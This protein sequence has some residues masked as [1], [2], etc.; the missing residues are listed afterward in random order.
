MVKVLQFKADRVFDVLR[1][2]MNPETSGLPYTKFEKPLNPQQQELYLSK[3]IQCFMHGLADVETGG[4][5]KIQAFGGSSDLPAIT[6]DVFDVTVKVDSYDLGWQKA[7]KGIQLQE[8]QLEWEI[9]DAEQIITFEEIL[10]GGK[11]Q[12]GEFTGSVAY[13]KIK[14]YGAGLAITWELLHGKKLYKFVDRMEITRAK[15]YE[16][17]ANVHYGML[18]TAAAAHAITWQGDVAD[19][20]LVRDIATLNHAAY[21]MANLLK[22]KG[23]GDMANAPMILYISPKYRARINAAIKATQADVI[24]AGGD[25]DIVDWPIEPVFTFDSRITA[26]KGDLVL[27]GHKIQNSVYLRELG[28]ARQEIESLA[29]LRTYWSAFG[30]TVADTE[31]CSQL[32]WS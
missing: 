2:R 12:Y 30:A 3:S 17:W 10:E 15:L 16:K 11:I 23:Y 4:Q 32:S 9:D 18:N 7:F 1:H 27:P 8:G 19:S 31:Q 25:G 22:N 24:R 5:V 13:G 6:K 29:E 20:Q 28:L 26:D 14:K 21:T